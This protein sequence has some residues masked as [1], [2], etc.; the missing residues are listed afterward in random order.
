MIIYYYS[1]PHHRTLFN[2]DALIHLPSLNIDADSPI[3]IPTDSPS[4]LVQDPFSN[5]DQPTRLSC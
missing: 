4:I 2:F 3:S 5:P 1:F